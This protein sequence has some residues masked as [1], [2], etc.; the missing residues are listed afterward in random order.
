MI[1]CLY[2]GVGNLSIHEDVASVLGSVQQGDLVSFSEVLKKQP[3]EVSTMTERFSTIACLEEGADLD[4]KGALETSP[5][6]A[7]SGDS[8]QLMQPYAFADAKAFLQASATVCC[9]RHMDFGPLDSTSSAFSFA[10]TEFTNH[11]LATTH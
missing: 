8:G 10:A 11:G 3:K 7:Y 9:P 1:S 6:S 5:A 4:I 2:I